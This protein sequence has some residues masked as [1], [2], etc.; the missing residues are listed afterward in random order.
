MENLCVDCKVCD[1]KA[2]RNKI[3]GPGAKG[4]GLG[5]VRNYEKWQ[6]VRVMLDTLVESGPVN[7]EVTLL[8]RKLSA[9]IMAGPVGAVQMHY[10]NQYDDLTYNDLLVKACKTIG[11]VG[12]T[13]DGMDP[14]VMIQGCQA[15]KQI[16]GAGIPTVKPWSNQAVKTKLDIVKDSQAMAVAMDV[17]AAGLPFL[18]NSAEPAGNKS[19]SELKELIEYVNKPFIVKGIMTVKGARKALEAGADAIIVSNHGGRV[20]DQCLATAEVLEEIVAEVNGRMCV[21]VD[22]GIRTGVDVFKALALGA[23]GVLVARPF[24][25]AAY[26]GGFDAVVQC[27]RQLIEELEDTML[28]CGA[29]QISDIT[30]DMVRWAK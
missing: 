20:L 17:D 24:V 30:R 14:Q 19:V 1:G 4:L 11:L 29:K 18:K 3:P 16:E 12:F 8:G 28:M 23:D 5:A 10:G 7:T 25:T 22:G 9:P 26:F 13:G 21:L 2:C 27:G 6:Q 15:I